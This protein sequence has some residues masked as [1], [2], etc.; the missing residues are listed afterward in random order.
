MTS[1]ELVARVR[2][3]LGDSARERIKADILIYDI[4]NFYQ[5]YLMVVKLLSRLKI[6]YPLILN[7]SEYPFLQNVVSHTSV[8]FSTTLDESENR[9]KISVSQTTS[10]DD[11]R[12]FTLTNSDKF[13]TGTDFMYSNAFVRPMDNERL[14][15]KVNPI[16]EDIYHQLL[17]EHTLSYFSLPPEARIKLMMMQTDEIS[18]KL[19]TENRFQTPEISGF[20]HLNF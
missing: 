17:I 9:P 14:T 11:A 13:V 12:L 3:Y 15:Q 2:E 16:V 8:W 10:G 4:L 1:I 18:Q 5:D 19:K 20:N 6:T 7:Q